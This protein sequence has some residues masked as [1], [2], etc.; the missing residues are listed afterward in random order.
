MK[1]ERE[2]ERVPRGAGKSQGT[3]AAPVR[4]PVLART[5]PIR[6]FSGVFGARAAAAQTKA[7]PGGTDGKT[8]DGGGKRAQRSTTAG[9]TGGRVRTRGAGATAAPQQGPADAVA[10][11]VNAGYRV[12]EEYLRQGQDFARSLWPGAGGGPGNGDGAADRATPFGFATVRPSG[13]SSSPINMT[14]RLIRSASDLAGLFSEFLQT[15]SLP[16]TLPAPGSSPI[17]DFGIGAPA[18]TPSPRSDDRRTGSTDDRESA[19]P[20]VSPAPFPTTVSIDLRSRRRTEVTATLAPGAWQERL[21]VHEL[22]PLGAAV[23]QRLTGVTAAAIEQERRVVL[24]IAVPDALAAETYSGLIVD[25]TSNL[26]R[27]TL[28]VRV[29]ADAAPPAPRTGRPARPRKPSGSRTG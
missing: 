27:G 12:I 14:E 11:G 15:F 28:S 5:Q 24:T 9:T 6:S 7:P 4:R 2:R 19:A 29:L 22:R 21:Q 16:G 17:P 26:P 13:S 8:G 25:A 3:P 1:R 10:R 20:V 23:T 18:A